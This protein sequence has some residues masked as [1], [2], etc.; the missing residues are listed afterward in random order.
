V[1]RLEN[2][3]NFII[4]VRFSKGGVQEITTSVF[5]FFFL[6]QRRCRGTFSTLTSTASQPRMMGLS[7]GGIHGWQSL[8]PMENYGVQTMSVFSYR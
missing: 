4:T 1:K 2:V 5:F 6:Q 7:N 3:K 8:E